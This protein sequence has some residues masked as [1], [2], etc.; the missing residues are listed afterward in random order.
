M[1]RWQ[2]HRGQASTEFP[3]D[4]SANVVTITDV[5]LV[6]LSF[7]E[8]GGI[9]GTTVRFNGTCK[10]G[11]LGASG[12]ALTLEASAGATLSC[13]EIHGADWGGSITCATG[14][15]AVTKT[16]S[17]EGEDEYG[18][19]IEVNVVYSRNVETTS[20]VTPETPVNPETPVAPTT[21]AVTQI[22]SSNDGKVTFT[23]D[24]FSTYIFAEVKA[25]AGTTSPKTG[26]TGMLAVMAVMLL[27]AGGCVVVVL[28]RRAV[29]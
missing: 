3:I 11:S 1:D 12:F 9:A 10:T 27:L 20:P 19:T 7:S 18:K 22:T 28:N 17:E 21:P 5:D 23:T 25:A 14:D 6:Y 26:E 4:A 24:H 16:A 15:Y 2:L 8:S 29:R 13:D